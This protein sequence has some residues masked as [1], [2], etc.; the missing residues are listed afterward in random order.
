MHLKLGLLAKETLDIQAGSSVISNGVHSSHL[1]QG[2]PMQVLRM[3]AKSTK[4]F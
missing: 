1:F 2:K 3:T 4:D